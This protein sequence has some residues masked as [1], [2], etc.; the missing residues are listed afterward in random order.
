[1][2]IHKDLIVVDIECTGS[3]SDKYSICEIG[4]AKVDRDTL[5]ILDTFTSLVRPLDDQREPKAMEVHKIPEEVLT[6]APELNQVLDSFE[7]WVGNE[8]VVEGKPKMIRSY[9]LAA[10]GTYFDITF[11]KKQYHKINRPYPFCHDCICLKSIAIFKMCEKGFGG[12]KWGVTSCLHKVG[13]KFIGKKHSALDDVIN[14]IR[15]LSYLR[16]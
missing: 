3:D 9:R 11:L 8:V 4:A 15:L 7:N 16:G 1:M 14:T 12:G 2:L 6:E 5:T 10:W 13:L